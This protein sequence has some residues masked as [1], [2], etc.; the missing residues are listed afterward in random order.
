M[1]QL[2]AAL[3]VLFAGLAVIQRRLYASA[4]CLLAALLHVSAV[5][6]VAGAPLVAFLQMMITGGAVMVLIVVTIMSGP[7]ELR[8][9]WAGVRVPRAAALAPAVLVAAEVAAALWRGGAQASGPASPGVESAI[10]AV[11]FG[12]YA[13]ATE[14]V[15]LLLFIAALAV[16]EPE[17][18]SR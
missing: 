16:F 18:A 3:A 12:P 9:P 11:L 15:A 2:A 17:R 1:V 4:A 13:L 14:A 10:G 8:R 6:F 7:G 5:L